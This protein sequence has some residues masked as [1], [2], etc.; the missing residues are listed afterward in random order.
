MNIRPP[1][2]V[3]DLL[4]QDGSRHSHHKAV[5]FVVIMVTLVIVALNL[6]RGTRSLTWPE[7]ALLAFL[8]AAAYGTGILKA[9]IA[10]ARSFVGARW[11]SSPAS[12]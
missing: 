6:L 10:L 12:S 9:V 8:V 11:P 5:A 7:V 3:F 4:E 2:E 1:S